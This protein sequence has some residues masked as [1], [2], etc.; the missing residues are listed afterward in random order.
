MHTQK[1]YLTDD[2]RIEARKLARQRFAH[3]NRALREL[4]AE[5]EQIRIDLEEKENAAVLCA[6]QA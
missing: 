5:R 2:E 4:Y 3:V 6:K 1:R